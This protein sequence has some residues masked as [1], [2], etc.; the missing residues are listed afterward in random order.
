MLCS[1]CCCAFSFILK[2]VCSLCCMP[3]ALVFF[4]KNV[5][6]YIE[7]AMYDKYDMFICFRVC[8]L[9][10]LP[11]ALLFPTKRTILDFPGISY[12]RNQRCSYFLGVAPLRAVHHAAS[13]FLSGQKAD[14]GF[15]KH[16]ISEKYMIFL[17]FSVRA[18]CSCCRAFCSGFSK[19]VVHDKSVIF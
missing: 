18:L 9:C 2:H 19:H 10:S 11:Q 12:L 16:V 6:P 14:P 4:R 3:Q 13:V 15:S 7:H 8:A 1:I 17:L 5:V